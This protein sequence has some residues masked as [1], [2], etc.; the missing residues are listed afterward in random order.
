MTTAPNT[1][2]RQISAQDFAML[3]ITDIA[4]VRS[5]AVD[6]TIVFAIHSADGNEVAQ[7]PTREAA[8]ATIIQNDLEPVG[9][10]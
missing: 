7:L 9:L 8:I 4:Y 2:L 6:E 3:G 1:D 10:Q 5:K